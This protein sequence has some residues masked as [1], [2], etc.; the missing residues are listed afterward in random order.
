MVGYGWEEYDVRDGGR[1]IIHDAGNNL[2]LTTEF[3]KIPGGNHGGNWAVRIKGTPREDAPTKLFTT[4]LFYT[5]LEGLGSMDVANKRDPLGLEGTVTIKGESPD[6]GDFAID[7]TEGPDSNMHPPPTHPSYQEKPLDRTLVGSFQ[8]PEEAIWQT[9]RTSLVS[10]AVD[11]SNRD[12]GRRVAA[13]KAYQ[14]SALHPPQ[15]RDRQLCREV[16]ERPE[17]STVAIVHNQQ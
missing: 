6:L 3:V 8:V 2:D 5:A 13:D 1:Q 16:R 9:K 10:A 12:V 15:E 17:S 4:V 11:G 7:I 14:S